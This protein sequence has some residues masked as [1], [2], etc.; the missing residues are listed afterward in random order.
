MYDLNEEEKQK[1]ADIILKSS[2]VYI[3][4]YQSSKYPEE[5]YL[6]LKKRFPNPRNVEPEDINNAI[7]WKYG[8]WG[9]S[10]FV[11]SHKVIISKIQKYWDEFVKTEKY[12]MSSIFYFWEE[13]LVG[14]QNFITIAFITH[15]IHNSRIEIID[16]HTF[17]A[18]NY[19]L[20]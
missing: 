20:K 16:Q 14:H 13:K 11:K 7:V 17:R 4:K 5:T 15:L 10:N 3:S 9:K 8:H 18:M 6:L 2:E 1:I 12:D 19:F